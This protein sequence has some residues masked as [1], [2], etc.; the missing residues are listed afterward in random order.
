M[1]NG[2]GIVNHSFDNIISLRN[3]FFAWKE[4]ERGKKNREDVAEFGLN[5][6]DDIFKLHDELKNQTYCHSPYYTF[7]IFDPKHRLISKAT[8]RDRIVHYLVFKELCRVF[9]PS[10]IYHSYSSR[11][12][13]GTHLAVVNGEK[14]LRKISRNYRGQAFILKCDIKKFFPSIDHQK[15]LSIIKNKITDPRFLWL[16]EEIISSFVSP[17]DKIPERERES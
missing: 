3:L 7:H 4:F 2:H 17:V 8:V 13:K 10:F 14:A 1:D 5:L 16:I 12:E 11:L 6:E 9:D 15:L